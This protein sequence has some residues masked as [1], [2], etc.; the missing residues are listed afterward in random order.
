[1]LIGVAGG[2]MFS[3]LLL[4]GLTG[5]LGLL[6]AF[7]AAGLLLAGIGEA[8]QAHKEREQV[9]RKLSCYPPYRY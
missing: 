3:G 7:C 6:L 9:R 2:L 8:V 5:S 1:M 4:G